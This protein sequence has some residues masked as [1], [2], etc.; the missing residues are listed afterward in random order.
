MTTIVIKF[1]KA[2]RKEI[3]KNLLVGIFFFEAIVKAR[4][5]R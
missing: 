2:N 3:K 4:A 5:A 1:S